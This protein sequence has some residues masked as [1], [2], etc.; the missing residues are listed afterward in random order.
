MSSNALLTLAGDGRFVRHTL[1]TI[2]NWWHQLPESDKVR[3]FWL[4]LEPPASAGALYDQARHGRLAKADAADPA[5]VLE[6]PAASG[7]PPAAEGERLEGDSVVVAAA[8]GAVGLG[9]NEGFGVEPASHGPRLPNPVV[10]V[11]GPQVLVWDP[12]QHRNHRMDLVDAARLADAGAIAETT[13]YSDDHFDGSQA[14]QY[15][16]VTDAEVFAK[17]MVL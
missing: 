10:D 5:S 1:E 12:A 17:E 6:L 15:F 14:T 2:D 8:D 7:M 9:Q 13:S 16:E 3:I 4:E 11:A